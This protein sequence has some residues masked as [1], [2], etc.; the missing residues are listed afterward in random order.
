MT[1]V[2]YYGDNLAVS[3]DSPPFNSNA[4]YNV[5]FKARPVRDRRRNPQS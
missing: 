4:S 3:L 1:N 2:L 5:L